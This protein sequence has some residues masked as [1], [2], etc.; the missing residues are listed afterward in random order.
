VPKSFELRD[1]VSV[2]CARLHFVFPFILYEM[3]NF[4][5]VALPANVLILPFIPFTMGLGFVTGFLGLIWYALAVLSG[6]FL[7]YF[8][9]TSSGGNQFF[10]Q[11]FRFLAAFSFPNFPLWLTILIYAYFIY[12]LFGRD[13][14]D[15]FYRKRQNIKFWSTDIFFTK[16]IPRARAVAL[17]S[18]QNL[19]FCRFYC[20][21][22]KF[23]SITSQFR[24]AKKSSMYCFFPWR[25]IINDIR[26]VPTYRCRAPNR[27]HSAGQCACSSI[28]AGISCLDFYPSRALPSPPP[29]S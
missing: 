9:I 25:L 15:F 8:C 5:L 23:S 18:L 19:T 14:K 28:Q 3:G 2:T 7:I 16:K 26:H 24:F 22:L 12:K 11:I 10:L 1:I 6:F 27:A 21:I 29:L 13:M 20:A 17:P 4:S